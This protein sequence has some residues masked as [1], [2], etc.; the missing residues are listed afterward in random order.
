MGLLC[1]SP[2]LVESRWTVLEGGLVDPYGGSPPPQE[3]GGLG[4]EQQH[5]TSLLTLSSC[6]DLAGIALG[7]G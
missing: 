5:R 4:I 6:C 3:A 2:V 1:G 7:R